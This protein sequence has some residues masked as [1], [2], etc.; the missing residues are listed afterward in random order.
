MPPKKK[1][2]KVSITRIAMIQLHTAIEHYYDGDYVSAIA[3]AGA[4]EEILGT[5]AKKRKGY[6]DFDGTLIFLSD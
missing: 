2:K 4:A 5:I 3:L 1:I 6:N